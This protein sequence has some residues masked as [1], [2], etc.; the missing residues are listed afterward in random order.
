[1]SV[2][3]P[4]CAGLFAGIGGFC[5]GF[6]KAGFKTAWVNEL[7][8]Y[9]TSVYRKNFKKT[10][11]IEKDVK[12]LSV[13]GDKLDPVDVLHAGFPCQSFSVAGNRKG[14]EDDRGKLFFEIIRL[15]EEFGSRRPK[16]LV[17]EN[18][19]HLLTGDNGTWIETILFK[20]QTLGYWVGI[21]NCILLNTRKHG[22]LPQNRERLFIVATSEIHSIDNP[23]TTIDEEKKIKDIKE[24][25]DI[26]SPQDKN[27]YLDYSNKYGKK[28]MDYLKNKK[29]YSLA[30]FRKFE[31]RDVPYGVCP[32]LTANMGQGGHN[33]PF[34]LDKNG[35]R[36]LTETECL[37]FQGF[38]KV[39]KWPSSLSIGR[40][41]Q[42]IGNAASPT[43]TYKIAKNII[44]NFDLME[45]TA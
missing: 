13:K 5:F 45:S 35:L 19:A 14:F 22:G 24:I 28:I 20:L 3:K 36:K 16:I 25:L 32:T 9:V 27:Y 23:F 44:S 17:L 31:I 11:V 37:S 1:M 18:V 7:D 10:R 41:Y 33:V 39:F 29:P 30:Q 34:L 40:K 42:M 2:E 38:P 12:E 15:V 6:E 4:T 8:S 21:E 43:I 26:E